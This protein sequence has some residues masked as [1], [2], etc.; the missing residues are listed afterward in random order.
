MYKVDI[1][2]GA[3]ASKYWASIE[4]V[5]NAGTKH[6][7]KINQEHSASLYSNCLEALIVAVGILNYPCMLNIYTSCEYIIEPFKQGWI[8]NWE[9]NGWTNAKGNIVRNAEQW[10]RVRNSLAPHSVR[11]YYS[12]GKS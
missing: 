1:E 8:G 3:S 4:F 9:K 12:G 10:K 2:I 6:R 5:D 7:R 11:F